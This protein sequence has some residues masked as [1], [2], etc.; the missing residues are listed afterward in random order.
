[1][2]WRGVFPAMTTPFAADLS[3]DHAELALHA[4]WLLE[5]RAAGLVALG[6][7]GEAATLSFDEKRAILGT[8]VRV[9]GSRAPLGWP[10]H[11][12]RWSLGATRRASWAGCGPRCWCRPGLPTAHASG[13]PAR[14]TP[15]GT[16]ATPATCT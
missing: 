9:A 5:H 3:V 16:G 6:S 8:C 15:A 14:D 7:L 10:V 2:S 11:R 4:A 12:A 13:C 1:M